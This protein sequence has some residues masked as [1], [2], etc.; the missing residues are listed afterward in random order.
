MFLDG[1]FKKNSKT[2]YGPMDAPFLIIV[3]I[4]VAT[5]LIMMF[6]ASYA[7]AFYLKNG[8]ST[9]Y[10][11][12]QLLAAAIGLAA[13]SATSM[14]DHRIYRLLSIPIYLVTLALLVIVLF[15]RPLNGARRWIFIG[16]INFQPSEIA[17]FAV[18]ILFAA[19]ICKYFNKMTK[20]RN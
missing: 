9:F 19:V 7:N 17:K 16:P 12:K 18:V 13:M 20:K 10:I 6:S 2:T 14:I 11:S 8:N 5:G 3:L 15:M 4:L 1:L